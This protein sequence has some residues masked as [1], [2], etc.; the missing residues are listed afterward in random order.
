MVGLPNN[1][2]YGECSQYIGEGMDEIYLK[3]RV[4]RFKYKKIAVCTKTS[5]THS[6]FYDNINCF[7][8]VAIWGG[9]ILQRNRS[10]TD[11]K[12]NGKRESDWF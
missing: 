5:L 1:T 7:Y 8:I 2:M 3:C 6:G 12:P 9:I 10:I 4:F 11:P